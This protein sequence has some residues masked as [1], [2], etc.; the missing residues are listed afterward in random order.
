MKRA[1]YFKMSKDKKEIGYYIVD[2]VIWI[3]YEFN[4]KERRIIC[5]KKYDYEERMRINFKK[6]N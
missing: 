6:N 3:E 1:A 4:K 2:D 5:T